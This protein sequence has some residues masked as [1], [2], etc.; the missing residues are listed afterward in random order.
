MMDLMENRSVLGK[1]CVLCWAMCLDRVEG[2]HE[3]VTGIG[4]RIPDQKGSMCEGIL[5]RSTFFLD[6]YIS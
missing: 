6:Q 3:G 4:D 5:K 1:I 2:G